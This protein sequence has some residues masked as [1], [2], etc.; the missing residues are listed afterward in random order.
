MAIGKDF[1]L[2]SIRG[3]LRTL[4]NQIANDKIQDPEIDDIIHLAVCHLVGRLGEAVGGDYGEREPVTLITPPDYSGVVTASSYDN[5]T[6]TATKA[7]HGLSVGTP[8]V[9]WDDGGKMA[10][11][12]VVTAPTS[13]TFTVNIAI[14]ATVTN[15]KYLE[16]TAYDGSAID[17][18]SYR[19]NNIVKLVDDANGLVV[20][21][22]PIEIEGEN[23]NPGR[24]KSS[25]WYRHGNYVY[26]VKGTSAPS[27]GTLYLYF[28]RIPTKATEDTDKL[29]IRDE[30]A[31][32]AID[33]AKVMIYETLKETPP[34]ALTNTINSSI[35]QI[36]DSNTKEMMALKD[37]RRKVK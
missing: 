8:I 17:I 23:R 16:F 20:E 7:T 18:S 25:Y 4:S 21:D 3:T 2:S 29:D 13:S 15:F 10:V 11:G 26:V 35:N 14:G 30:F 6:K 34:E 36:I 22:N 12:Y 5:S 24:T 33:V 32:L 27:F 28:N 37:T 9:Y 1:T 31:K 19:I